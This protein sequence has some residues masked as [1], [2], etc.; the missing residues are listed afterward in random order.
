MRFKVLLLSWL[1]SITVSTVSAHP[2][3]YT[4]AWGKV[5]DHVDMKLSVFLD[6]IVRHQIGPPEDHDLISAEDLLRAI[7]RHSAFLPTQLKIFDQQGR[8]LTASVTAEPNWKPRGPEVKLSDNNLL[9]LTW[10]LRY[11]L[12]RPDPDG[13]TALCFL[14]SFTHP[15][16]ADQ[17]ELRMHLQQVA[18]GNRIDAVI[19]PAL[20]HTMLLPSEDS[21]IEQSA[22][23]ANRAMS[24]LVISPTGLV[25]EFT[26]PLL[27]LDGAW[28]PAKTLRNQ[29][30]S[31]V[32]VS[33]PLMI[34]PSEIAATKQ[35]IEAWMRSN[36]ELKIG[37]RAASLKSL[38]VDF[39]PTGQTPDEQLNANVSAF[40]GVPL[41]GTQV[42]VR[43]QCSGVGIGVGIGVSQ[44]VE[45]TFKRSPGVFDIM[46]VEVTSRVGQ[47]SE[48]VPVSADT[49]QPAVLYQ[50]SAAAFANGWM[51]D[52]T[53]AQ[54]SLA[55]TF[56][57]LRIQR[58]RP[59]V[60]GL[61]YG[62]VGLVLCVGFG[63]V[64]Q[65]AFKAFRYVAY[66][67]GV[68]V[69]VAS[70]SLVEDS[71]I[72]VDQSQVAGLASQILTGVYHG[73]MSSSEEDAMAALSEV[74]HEDLVEEVY[75]ATLKSLSSS[76]ENGVI[77]DVGKVT[78]DS[79]QVLPPESADRWT[80]NCCW[81]V[82]GIV[83]HWGHSHARELR[84]E[85]DLTVIRDPAGWKLLSISQTESTNAAVLATPAAVQ[86]ATQSRKSGASDA[87]V[88]PGV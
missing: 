53:A 9:K 55:P 56:D 51:I 31:A 25:H 24:R 60:R 88:V 82:H 7:R 85:G 13:V 86:P 47:T 83:H 26:A 73:A 32:G 48:Q 68:C 81:N 35:Q 45:L 20:P 21:P 57:P 28:P 50:W 38:T 52:S 70:V 17:G 76:P 5:S 63:L 87:G 79:V 15:D 69:F 65:P 42:G 3:S 19:P 61:C 39:F 78:V 18:S 14:H 16:L 67:A 23:E 43:M 64:L 66:A 74:L 22:A 11:A 77:I 46:T 84:L 44:P 1:L 4:D 37:R 41:F 80:A 29:S 58:T 30:A 2:V 36:V 49:T 34:D 75:L 59:G 8:P 6:D 71:K 12:D 54:K 72:A 10:R 40:K 33:V 62:I 27:Y